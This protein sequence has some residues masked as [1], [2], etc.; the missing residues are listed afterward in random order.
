M[1]AVG[2]VEVVE[3]PIAAKE[4]EK[5]V[6]R[7]RLPAVNDEIQA[8]DR[9]YKLKQKLGDGGYGIVFLSEDGE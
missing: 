6:E 9:K 2:M 7:D 4:Q 1:A 3:K 8:D 5:K